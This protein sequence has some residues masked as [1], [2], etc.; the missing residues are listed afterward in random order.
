MIV[1]AYAWFTKFM[2]KL[3]MRKLVT[4]Q[5]KIYV[6]GILQKAEDFSLVRVST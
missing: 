6:Y 5:E 2:V 4:P 1:M 3:L